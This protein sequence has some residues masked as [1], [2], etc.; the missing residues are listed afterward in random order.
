MD[1]G[2]MEP[3]VDDLLLRNKLQSTEIFVETNRVP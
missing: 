3:D 2:E 1:N